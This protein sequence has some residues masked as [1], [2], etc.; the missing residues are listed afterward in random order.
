MTPYGRVLSIV[1]PIAER[2]EVSVDDIMGR[3][4]LRRITAAR[5]EAFDAVKTRLDMTLC[6]VAHYFDRDHTTVIYGI[7]A[8]RKSAAS[9]YAKAG[10]TEGLI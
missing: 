5:F 10:I 8:H 4:R 6:D 1:R 7:S 9:L 3:S 2:H